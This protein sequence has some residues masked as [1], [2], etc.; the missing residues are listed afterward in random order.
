[1]INI[2]VV[3]LILFIHWLADFHMQTHEMSMNKSKSNYW[4]TMHVLVYTGVTFLFWN[5][6][7]LQPNGNYDFYSYARF[8]IFIFSSHWVTDYIT[9]RMTSKLYTQ[10]KFHDFFVVIGFDQLLHAA[11]LFAAY[12][13][14][15]N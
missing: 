5:F 4:L 15:V 6:F 8:F 12:Y 10:S 11:Q 14:F 1:M 3:L 2:G 7:L 9:S 13:C